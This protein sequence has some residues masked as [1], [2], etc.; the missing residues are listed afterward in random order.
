MAEGEMTELEILLQLHRAIDAAAQ[1]SPE[2]LAIAQR[3]IPGFRVE[4]AVGWTTESLPLVMST[5][6]PSA[7][8]VLRELEGLPEEDQPYREAGGSSAKAAD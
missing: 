8:D 7:Q 4:G 2:A 5:T 1:Q 6:S 3:F